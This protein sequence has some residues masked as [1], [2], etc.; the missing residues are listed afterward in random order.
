MANFFDILTL[1]VW[2]AI[3]ATVLGS[4]HTAGVINS[5]AN[6]FSSSIKAAKGS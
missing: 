5:L 2:L 3:I 4:S 1:I 6:A